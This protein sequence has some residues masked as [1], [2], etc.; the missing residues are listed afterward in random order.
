MSSHSQEA[1]CASRMP[2]RAG[3]AGGE[4]WRQR[5][6]PIW[7][8]TSRTPRSRCVA[9]ASVR[10][11]ASVRGVPRAGPR[12]PLALPEEH[13]AH[14]AAGLGHAA[15]HVAVERGRVV[16]PLLPALPVADAGSRVGDGD[17]RHRYEGAAHQS[18]SRAAATRCRRSW[19][20]GRGSPR[21][22][23]RRGCR[24]GPRRIF[25]WPSLPNRLGVNRRLRQVCNSGARPQALLW[26]ATTKRSPTPTARR[27][28]LTAGRRARRT[29]SVPCPVGRPERTPLKRPPRGAGSSTVHRPS[30]QRT[31]TAPL[32]RTTPEIAMLPVP[33]SVRCTIW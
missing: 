21:R 18:V 1:A 2:S 8:T 26:P 24:R 30:P 5:I 33:A 17:E 11:P 14:G 22:A 25:Q 13:G 20:G 3:A 19:W 15:Q 7:Q 10:R 27:A 12:V 4:S 23:A 31:S 28:A 6:S 29:T 16:G 32:P 9:S